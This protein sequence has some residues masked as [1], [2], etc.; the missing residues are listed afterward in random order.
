MFAPSLV[1]L[2]KI[3]STLGAF[4]SVDNHTAQAGVSEQWIVRIA[5]SII[6]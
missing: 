3:E 1:G 5:K 6:S 4:V 2:L